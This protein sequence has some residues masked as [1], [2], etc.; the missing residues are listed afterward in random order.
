VQ[1]FE[2]VF[3]GDVAAALLN[4]LLLDRDAAVTAV[5]G[6]ALAFRDLS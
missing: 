3:A 1:G 2:T 4:T 6:F 5:A